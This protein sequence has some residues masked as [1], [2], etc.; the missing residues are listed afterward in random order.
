[1][2]PDMIGLTIEGQA[3]T[4][5][6]FATTM[7]CLRTLLTVLSREVAEKE[8]IVWHIVDLKAGSAMI[9]MQ[10]ES[11]SPE[12][13]A[14][15]I[16]AYGT[17][18]ASLQVDAPIPYPPRIVRAATG[19]TKVIRGEVTGLRFE[20]EGCEFLINTPRGS[21][22]GKG[23]TRALG[24][25][26]GRIETITSHRTHKLLLYDDL[27]GSPIDC[28]VTREQETLMRNAWNKRAQVSGEV[29]R[30]LRSGRVMAVHN[31]RDIRILL[32]PEPDAL[33]HAQGILDL[34]KYRAEE[35]VR[36]LRDAE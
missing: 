35:L 16:R 4:L 28:L 20:A 23:K 19:L 22:I 14:R 29:I 1:M 7:Q 17:I 8:T 25:V 26:R 34:G 12:T 2:A 9:Y 27:F 24:I 18:A 30:D 3:I 15:T 32:D 21:D 11:A 6:T 31:I 10:G 33:L 36:S 13:I 5:D